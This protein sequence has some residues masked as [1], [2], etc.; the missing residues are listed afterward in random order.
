MHLYKNKKLKRQI[1]IFLVIKIKLLTP[2]SFNIPVICTRGNGSIFFSN[3]SENI[4]RD[5]LFLGVGISVNSLK[6]LNFKINTIT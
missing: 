6:Q 2:T 4:F 5:I 3:K 1:G